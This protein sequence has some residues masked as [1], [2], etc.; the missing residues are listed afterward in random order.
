M[1]KKSKKTLENEDA[2]C[3]NIMYNTVLCAFFIIKEQPTMDT[4]SL[5]TL[6]FDDTL[7]S[8]ESVFET[9]PKRA[10]KEGEKVTRMAPSPT[11]FMHLGN[12]YA[13]LTSERLAHLSG[14]TFY[15]RIE[16][17]DQKREVEG[18]VKA[19]IDGLSHFGLNFDEGALV[20]G[21]K[22][23]YGPYRQRQ[24]AKIY[25][26]FAKELV[27][28]GMAYPCFCSEE[29]L[30]EMRA[31]QEA[32]KADNLGYRGKWA[33]CRSLSLEEIKDKLDQKLPW[34]LRFRSEGSVENKFKFTD[35]V[36]GDMEL[37]ENDMDVVILKSDGIPTYHFA[38]VVDDYLMGT[39]HVVRGD[40]WIATLPIHL[41]LYRAVGLKA[42]KY[43]HIA[44]L[45]KMDGNTKRK[46]SKRK[47]PELALSFYKQE[48]YVVNCVMVYLMTLLNSNF[49]EWY[50]QNPDKSYRDFPFSPKK[51]SV[52]GALFDL[53]K[54]DDVSK[55][56]LAKLKNVELYELLEA[57]TK[58]YD[59]E[60]YDIITA[61]KE[62]VLQILNIGRVGP[63]PRKDIAK[64]SEIKDYIS[65]FF[66]ALYQPEYVF[67]ENIS[68]EDR[69]AL[70]LE[71]REIYDE[72]DTQ[73]E[74]FQKI[75]D[76]SERHGFTANMKEYKKNP[77]A[78]KG[79]VAQVSTVLRVQI[80]GRQNTPDTYE[81]FKV[82]GNE[83][84]KARLSM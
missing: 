47:D 35:L 4:K 74:W 67:P 52:S 25:Q 31:R 38:H 28:K 9:Y 19:I 83:L 79:N 14:G 75:K 44:P 21:E 30:S 80:C 56:E 55:N 20:E 45:M 23:N 81:V 48:G 41:Q 17:T 76:L 49:E 18:G 46:L 62:K 24:R 58:E 61:E 10:L 12:L 43:M 70:I 40:E 51:M 73:D 53:V 71:Y 54:L 6:L 68:E 16:D 37:S 69:K 7:P 11:G 13:A 34:V 27:L 15:L 1:P 8:L 63:K 22:G 84:V 32:E 59:K 65:Y 78:Y 42:P 82:M 3:Y 26:A 33:K 77:D 66:P 29:E 64:L 60:F 50:A 36:K 2:F 72:N 57:Y 5:A 39:T